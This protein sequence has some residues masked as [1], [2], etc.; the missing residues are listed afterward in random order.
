MTEAII[1]VRRRMASSILGCSKARMC[2]PRLSKHAMMSWRAHST[3]G[4]QAANRLFPDRQ[5]METPKASQ[6]DTPAGDGAKVE[7][8]GAGNTPV[9][10]D[11]L[12]ARSSTDAASNSRA[13]P[14]R[15]LF[16]YSE[17]TREYKPFPAAA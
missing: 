17:P 1:N 9:A 16:H 15:S 6:G 4:P 2:L 11:K 10:E 3:P 13:D 5:S 12:S 7:L 14:L 8:A